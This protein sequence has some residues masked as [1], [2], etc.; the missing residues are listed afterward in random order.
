MG[1]CENVLCPVCKDQHLSPSEGFRLRVCVSQPGAGTDFTGRASVCVEI[2]PCLVFGCLRWI[3][4]NQLSRAARRVSQES[5]KL[6]GLVI[7]YHP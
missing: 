5:S 7:Y 2:F 1:P 4:L 6:F 3:V